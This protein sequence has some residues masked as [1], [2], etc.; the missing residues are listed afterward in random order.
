MTLTTVSVS[1]LRRETTRLLQQ[2]KEGPLIVTKRG[3]PQVVVLDYVEYSKLKDQLAE[4]GDETLPE[5]ALFPELAQSR[6]RTLIEEMQRKY[7]KYPS[8][9]QALLAERARERAREA[10]DLRS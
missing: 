8:F 3:R 4:P 6:V 7:A 10:K 9:T 1:D 5:E 2:A